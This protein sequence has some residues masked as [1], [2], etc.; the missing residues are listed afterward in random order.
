MKRLNLKAVG[1]VGAAG[2]IALSVAGIQ[3]AAV[4][5]QSPTPQTPSAVVTSTEDVSNGPDTGTIDEQVG[6]QTAADGV[7]DTAETASV[8]VKTADTDN[9]NVDQQVGDQTTTDGVV[10]T[11]GT[12]GAEVKAN[13]T[14]DVNVDQQVGDQTGADN[15]ST[16]AEA[17]N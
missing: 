5:A 14:N 13:G 12:T 4:F 11:V 6:D 16:G 15:A 2:M 7:V 8:E 1:A 3:A 10:D 17:G 9:V